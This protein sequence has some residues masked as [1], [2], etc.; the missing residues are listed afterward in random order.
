MDQEHRHQWMMLKQEPTTSVVE[1][2][3]GRNTGS[4]A[5]PALPA[6]RL[7]SSQAN[8]RT[9]VDS[10]SR[11]SSE[12]TTPKRLS[13]QQQACAKRQTFPDTRVKHAPGRQPG[14]LQA[15]SEGSLCTW[16]LSAIFL[17]D[18]NHQH[19]R[20]QQELI[21]SPDNDIIASDFEVVSKSDERRKNGR[22]NDATDVLYCHAY[23]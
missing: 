20:R 18:N 12:N 13:R 6:I 16:D 15:D 14:D 8:P 5:Q 23:I 10:Y 4:R 21:K 17:E 9:Y 7:E 1:L 19:Q 2:L 11:W 22:C 3:G